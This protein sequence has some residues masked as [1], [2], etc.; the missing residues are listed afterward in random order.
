[1]VLVACGNAFAQANQGSITGTVRD[2]SG[3]V[4]PNAPLEVRNSATGAVFGGGA[5]ATGNF[6]VPV[7]AGTY[8][9]SVSVTGF[10]RFVQSGIPVVEGQATRRDVSLEVGQVAEVTTVTDT[11]PLL[12]TES[13]DISYRVTAAETN[14]LPLI[15][16]GGVGLGAIRNPL[17]MTTVIPGV[18]YNPAGFGGVFFQTL[19]VN[20]LPANSQTWTIEGQD[21][22]PTLWRGVTSNRGQPSVDAIDAMTVQ[23]SNFA[24]E[25]GKAGGAAINYAMKSGTNQLHGSVYD[26]FQNEFLN[27][28]IPN[29]DWIDQSTPL[30][31]RAFD[32]KSGQHIRNRQRRHDYGFTIGGPVF[33]PKAYDGRD[34]T[35]FFFNFEQYRETQHV[36]AGLATVPTPAYRRG[37][38]TA[39]GCNDFDTASLTCRFRQPVNF[40]GGGPATDPTGTQLLAG[41]IYD[42]NTYR[43]VNGFPVRTLFP[44]QQV[45][46]ARMDRVTT[47]IQE[48]FPLPNNP[49]LSNN[50]VVA[51]YA[52]WRR[53]SI[54]AMK[55]DHI[56][57]S[58]LRISG[59]WSQTMT[60]QNNAN[61]FLPSEFPWSAAQSTPYRNH[62]IRVNIDQTITP[63]LLLH[64][65]VGY[66]HQREPNLATEFDHTKIGLPGAG[67]VNAYPFPNIFPTIGLAALGSTATAGSGGFSPGIGVGF[68]AIAYEQKP[69]ANLNLTWVK[70]NHTLKFGGDTTL[71]GYPTHNKWR[72]NGNFVFG[73][74]QTGN[75]WELGQGLN[76]VNP[77]GFAYASFLMGQPDSLSLAQPTFTR[78]GGHAYA[79]FAQD[80]WRVTRKLTIGYGLRYDFQTYL[81]EQHGRHASASFSTLNPTVGRLGGLAYEATCNCRLSSNYPFAFGPRFNLAYQISNKTVIRT[82]FGVN[83]NVVQTPAGNNFSVGDFFQINNPG[84]GLT[85][86]PQ[87]FAAGNSFYPGNPFGNTEVVWPVFDPGRI[88][89]QAGGLLPP[90]SPFSMYHPGSRPARIAQ[91]SVSLQHEVIRNLVVEAIYIGNRGVWFYSP[92]LDVQAMNSLGGGVLERYGLDLRKAEDRALLNQNIGVGGAVN[93]AAAARGIGIPYNRFPLTQQVG[94]AIRPVPQWQ[95]V[96]AYLGPNRG[97]TWYD[98]LQLQATKRA[99]HNLDVTANFT[100]AKGLALGATSDT[101]FFLLGRPLL[102]DPFNRQI[103]KQINQL[104]PPYKAVI[105]FLYTTPGLPGG[106]RGMSRVASHLVKDWQIGGMLQ[107][108][109]GQLLPMPNSNN[110]LSSQLRINAP[111]QGAFGAGVAN[112]NPWNY[113]PGSPF[114]RPGFDPNGD[115]DPRT[116]NPANPQSASFLAGG[117]QPNG[118]CNVEVCSWT[119]PPFGEWGATAP[120][121][122]GFRWRRQ[123]V[124]A[125]NVG[126]NFR[127]GR[128]GRFLLSVRAEFQNVMNRMFYAPPSTANPLQ[129]VTTVTQRGMVI[130]ISGFGVINTLNGLGSNPRAGL[131]VMRFTF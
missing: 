85:A 48:L 11:A 106:G 16:L 67:A 125:F 40:I 52:N 122:E 90:T 119:N 54:P 95:T 8:E 58:R 50:Y 63:T 21:A 128:E 80:N 130:P 3:A 46:L 97:N 76:L 2:Q 14:R 120:V 18:Q 33:L 84:Y 82:G 6:V 64:V 55:I 107:Y 38:F 24:A 1:L 70:G 37:D 127:M 12:K 51:P 34:K 86:M 89:P 121:L 72:A 129:A 19:T 78:L 91:W 39:A 36:S 112:Y 15:P 60:N 69:T 75:P 4:I 77:S 35:W 117:I 109:N 65:G 47:R 92:L 98:A 10:R 74:A 43:I 83:Y 99:S 114:Y 110:Q 13:G 45:P 59:Y 73:P 22:T 53:M 30:N 68:H 124:E 111:A 17:F 126:R 5:S 79:F 29:T 71:Q 23:T 118:T 116:Y 27:A 49:N 26:Y 101:D 100:W 66:F 20:G 62:T 104:V 103:N 93:P 61:G 105:S 115:F 28:G 131:M 102:T 87:G 7:P 9:L 41:G 96:N 31:N 123:P 81:R 57:S 25:F 113:I 56:L 108:Q 88:P 42:P 44:N 32:Y 94:Q